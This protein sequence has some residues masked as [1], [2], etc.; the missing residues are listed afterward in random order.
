ME[1][2]YQQQPTPTNITGVPIGLFVLDSNNNYRQ[3]G[4]TTSDALGTFTYT[5]TPDI[6]GDFKVYA[7]FAGSNSYWPSSAS[8]G[9]QASLPATHE[10][11]ATVAQLVDNTMTIMGIGVAIIVVI[12]IV[13]AVL[14]MMIRKRP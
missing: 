13:G 8:A 11:T 2:V 3:I 9:F 10:P 7:I 5:W 1:T 4:T 6:P 14:A 12:V